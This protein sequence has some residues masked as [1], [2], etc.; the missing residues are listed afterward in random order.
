MSGTSLSD[1]TGPGLPTPGLGAPKTPLLSADE[2]AKL[3][4]PPVAAPAAKQTLDGTPN[5]LGKDDFLKLLMAQLANQD[6]LKPMDDTQFISQ[7]AQFNSLEQA[8]QTTQ[9][10]ADLMTSQSLGQASSLIGKQITG[11]DAKGES[12]NGVVD[13]V[14]V[15]NGKPLLIVGTGQGSSQVALADVTKVEDAA[16]T[17]ST[18]GSSLDGMTG[19]G[20]T[21]TGTSSNGT[22][23]G[24][25]SG[26]SS[27]TS[28]SATSSS[29]GSTSPTASG[30]TDT[31]GTGT[32]ATGTTTTGSTSTG[33]TTTGST[34]TTG[35]TS[36]TSTTGTT[37]A[38]GTT[39]P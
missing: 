34:G 29:S 17:T 23:G 1:V 35:T 32:T 3:G 28:S 13:H 26:T 4:L 31:T 37:S 11:K 8:T 7:L 16:D 24:S 12:V 19:T 14:Q 38:T 18:D 30:S 2:R 10:L 33:T 39:T 20:T 36:T 9:H 27:N 15:I 5:G 22:T 21:G 25:T 6:P